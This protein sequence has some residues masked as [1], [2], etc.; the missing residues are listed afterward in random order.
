MARNNPRAATRHRPRYDTGYLRRDLTHAL[1]RRR[2]A[3]GTAYSTLQS[4]LSEAAQL[5][6]GV[7]QLQA[8]TLDA[9]PGH[10]QDARGPAAAPIRGC[11]PC[12]GTTR[13]SCGW[14]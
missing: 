10:A 1:A 11:R 9:T 5:A 6:V 3:Y 4:R 2:C 7:C 8:A 12:C 13:S 14:G